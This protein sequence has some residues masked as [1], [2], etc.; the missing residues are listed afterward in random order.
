MANFIRFI[1]W[2]IGLTWFFT[3]KEAKPARN[4]L[5][6]AIIGSWILMIIIGILCLILLPNSG[7]DSS[8]VNGW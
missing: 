7:V 4:Y 2:T 5:G 3:S 8:R 1:L 6:L